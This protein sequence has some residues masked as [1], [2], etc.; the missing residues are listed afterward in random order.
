[1]ATPPNAIVYGSGY[2]TIPQMARAGIVL[3]LLFAALI[4]IL[5][6]TLMMWV[7]GVSLGE[8]PLWAAGGVS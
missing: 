1:V 6:Y 8:I 7:F 3:N 2:V 4:T 5:A